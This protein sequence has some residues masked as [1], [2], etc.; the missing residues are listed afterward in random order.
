MVEVDRVILGDCPPV[1]S[2]LPG[3]SIDL[4][5]AAPYG[6]SLMARDWTV[7]F[8]AFRSDSR[9]EDHQLQK[10]DIVN[11]SNTLCRDAWRNSPKRDSCANARGQLAGILC[12]FRL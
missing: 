10:G 6:I 2:T 3:E 11:V 7:R 12:T 9:P 5:I 8:R 4:I 1:L